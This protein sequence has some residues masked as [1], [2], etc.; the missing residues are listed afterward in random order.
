MIKGWLDPVIAS[1]INFT[2]KPADLLQF[3]DAANLQTDYGGQDG[4]SYTYIEPTA[5]EN[6][7]LAEPEKRHEIERARDELVREFEQ[8]TIAW[9]CLKPDTPDGREC[10]ARRTE[11][12]ERLRG[13]YW[14]LDPYI[15][16]RTLQHRIEAAEGK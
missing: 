12:A 5:G 6:A 7:R 16:A 1:K 8:D 10:A 4:W 13:N 15:R 2:R 11:G 9:A 14:L 3:I